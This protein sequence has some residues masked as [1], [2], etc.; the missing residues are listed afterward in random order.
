MI[1][2]SFAMGIE[3]QEVPIES[4]FERLFRLSGTDSSTDAGHN[5]DDGSDSGSEGEPA[6]PLT[7]SV[8]NTRMDI[9]PHV[10]TSLKKLYVSIATLSPIS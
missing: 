6:I 4:P 3:H 9:P 2:L 8:A 1:G 10:L 5:V 7:L